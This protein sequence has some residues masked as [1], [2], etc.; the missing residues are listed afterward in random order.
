[1]DIVTD[2][3]KARIT[4]LETTVS[5]LT[6]SLEFTQSEVHDLKSEVKELK[7]SDNEQESKI[8]NYKARIDELEHKINY[9]EDYSRRNNL[10]FSGVQELLS[11]ETWEQTAMLVIK[12]LDEKLQLSSVKIAHRVGLKTSS[13]PR[14]IVARFEHFGDRDAVLRNARKLKG[15][16]I[17]IN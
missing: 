4:S 6:R 5:D 14:V 13:R 11:G 12:L 8:G 16:G 3:M 1:M 7:K 15:T 2:Q 17:F 9:Q 10:R